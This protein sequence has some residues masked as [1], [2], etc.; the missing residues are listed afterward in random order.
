MP[1]SH[2][3]AELVSEPLVCKSERENF[4]RR[5][6][7]KKEKGLDLERIKCPNSSLLPFSF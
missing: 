4:V 1:L 7:K 6:K 2:R 3:H 5:N